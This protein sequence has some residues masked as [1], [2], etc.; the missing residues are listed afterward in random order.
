MCLCQ[1]PSH[2]NKKRLRQNFLHYSSNVKMRGK[3]VIACQTLLSNIPCYGELYDYDHHSSED[4]VTRFGSPP[5]FFP[6]LLLLLLCCSQINKETFQEGRDTYGACMSTTISHKKRRG[7]GKEGT[8]VIKVCSIKVEL[9]H[10]LVKY[11]FQ[12]FTWLKVPLCFTIFTE[13]GFTVN[14]FQLR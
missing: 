9:T 10:H 14:R 3:T 7:K 5:Q 6:L 11:S 13:F 12:S 4:F 2:Q 1:L 8:N